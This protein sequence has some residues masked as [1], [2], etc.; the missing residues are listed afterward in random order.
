MSMH[1]LGHN[2]GLYHGGS[3]T[4]APGGG[5]FTDN[6]KPN[7]VS[8]MNY[9]YSTQ[10]PIVTSSTTSPSG[11]WYR[12]DYSDETLP[13]LDEHNLD[14]TVGIGPTL[15]PTDYIYWCCQYNGF[16]PANG[17]IDWNTNGTATDTGVSADL[18]N[19]GSLSVLKGF[20]DWDEVH[21]YLADEDT[22]PKQTPVGTP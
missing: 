1:E 17:P 4:P 16:A 18:N 22:H 3:G 7:Y 8:V 15:H 2:L 14:E 21:Q 10:E 6:S 13:P 5:Y 9:S 12:V 20:N 19:D 11:Y